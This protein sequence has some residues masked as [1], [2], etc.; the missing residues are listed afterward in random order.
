MG[1]RLF[2]KYTLWGRAIVKPIFSPRI[3]QYNVQPETSG[4]DHTKREDNFLLA[5]QVIGAR[6]SFCYNASVANKDPLWASLGML[7]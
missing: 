6:R 2:P 3:F 5:E 7:P 4:E 1:P